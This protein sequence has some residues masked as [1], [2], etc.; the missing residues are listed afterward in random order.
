MP[1]YSVQLLVP[2]NI[3]IISYL[4][5]SFASFALLNKINNIDN[6]HSTLCP[7]AASWIT[8]FKW[9]TKALSRLLL[10]Y[11]GHLYAKEYICFKLEKSL[12]M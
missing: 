11:R 8:L 1:S 2:I 5:L 4:F 10:P 12:K 3:S 9:Q 7:S 6:W